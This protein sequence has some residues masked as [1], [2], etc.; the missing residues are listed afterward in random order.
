MKIMRIIVTGL[1]AALF[2]S[3]QIVSADTGRVEIHG[4]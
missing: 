2:L 3:S 1:F 4:F